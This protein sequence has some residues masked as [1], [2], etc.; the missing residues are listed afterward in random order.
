MHGS[1]ALIKTKGFA[2]PK[3]WL[4]IKHDDEYVKKDYNANDYEISAISGKSIE[5]I[6]KEK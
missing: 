2:G 3:A 5:E 4:L 1:F 6:K